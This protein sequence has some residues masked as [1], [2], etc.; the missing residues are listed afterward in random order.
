MEFYLNGERLDI[1]LEGEKT[2]GEV[3]RSFEKTAQ[4][5][6]CATI[7]IKIDGKKIEAEDF[8]KAAAQELRGDTRIEL[9]AVSQDSVAQAFKKSSEE[10]SKTIELLLELPA[11]LQSGSNSK[12]KN[13][14]TQLAD[15]VDNFCHV[16]VL[17]SLF[18]EKFGKINVDGKSLSEFFADFTPIFNDLNGAMES[19]DTVLL[20]D[21]AEYEISPR[22]KALAEAVKDL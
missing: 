11:L 21:L 13:S 19:G 16:T 3:L 18:P 4:E 7:A 15:V 17:S 2:V 5:N 1:T 10:I 20:G 12:A 6:N 8:D 22:L 14:I 9:T